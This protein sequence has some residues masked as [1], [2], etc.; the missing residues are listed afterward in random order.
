MILIFKLY[1]I[2]WF[3][4]NFS[5]LQDKLENV[6]ELL[7]DKYTKIQLITNTIYEVLSCQK[8]MTLWLI[9]FVTL[10]PYMAILGAMIAQI[11]QTLINK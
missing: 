7:L 10:N 11:H 3:I 4:T 9:L 1:L 6:T 5:P 2:A 8:C